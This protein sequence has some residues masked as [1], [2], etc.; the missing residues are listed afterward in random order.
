M[1]KQ[2][3]SQ[4][5]GRYQLLKI[6][7]KGGMGEVWL[8]YDPLYKR[9]VAIKCIRPELKKHE[10]LLYRFEHEARISA[11]LTHPGIV[12]IYEY[13]PDYY[14]M[15]YIAGKTLK[16]RIYQDR[17]S[18]GPLVA[19][20]FSVCH[21]I[22][23]IHAK[24]IL[25]RDLKPE[26]IL[27][28][29]FG[30]VILL[31]WGLAQELDVPMEDDDEDI[32]VEEGLT[33]PGKLVGTV[34]YMA[35][36]RALGQPASMQSEIYALGV[37]LYQILTLQLPFERPSLKEFAKQL[38]PR[39][40]EALD[41]EEVAPYRGIPPLLS[42]IVMRM[43]H[44]DPKHRYQDMESVLH[45]LTMHSEGRSDWLE[46]TKLSITRKSDWQFQENV[47]ISKHIALTG[48]VEESD[49][50]SV[51]ISKAAF[52]ENTRL[53]TRIWIDE[54]GAGIGFLLSIPEP[55]ERE[56]PFDG[57]CL[58]LA[59]SP[60][61][62]SLLFRNTVEVMNL[63]ELYLKKGEWHTIA[64]EKM[65]RSIR[66][67]VDGK[68][69]MTYISY[70]P[71]L[72]THVGII[73]K[74]ANFKLDE[75]LIKTG[76]QTL[77]VS[78]LAI[79]DAFLAHKHYKHALAEYRRIG[80]SFAGYAEGREG[81]FRA[82]ITLIEQ[83][84]NIKQRVKAD[85]LFQQALEDFSKLHGTAGAP[86][87]Y[88]GKSIVYQELGDHLEEIKCLELGLRRYAK[89]PLIDSLRDQVTYRMHEAAQ[90]DRR[91]AYQLMLL[92]LRLLPA[93][94]QRDDTQRLFA[95]LLKHWEPLAFLE[96]SLDAHFTEGKL[97]ALRFA[98]PL[99]F[100]LSAPYILMELYQDLLA[101]TVQDEAA[102]QDILFALCELGSY[103]LAHK[104]LAEQTAP[105]L[106]PI[107]LCHQTSLKEA[108]RT[109]QQLS[110]VDMGVKELRTL[111]YLMR[112]AL[113]QDQEEQVHHMADLATK[114]PL[115]KEDQIQIDAYRIWAFLKAED[116]R[117]AGKI[118]DL[119][120]LELLNQ[121][122]TLLHPLFGC[123]LYVTEGEEIAMIHFSGVIETPHPRSFALVGHEL[124]DHISQ[125]A[126][127]YQRSF[128]WE[129]RLLYSLLSLYYSLAE[130]PEQESYYKKLES[131][132]YIFAD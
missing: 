88:L 63:P 89:H 19:V 46:N 101:S 39:Y 28:G 69:K 103:Q 34:A 32:T 74:D 67:F 7:G 129:R 76:G 33:H 35:P 115:S 118:F 85:R 116:W 20:F 95:Y 65:G 23:Y 17:A 96:S 73:S 120:P 130:N 12:S 83:A 119:Y 126:N 92:V 99:A 43:I 94:L 104:L 70:L 123:Y 22:A 68:E 106:S 93:T 80:S 100:W 114:F 51:M 122:S 84:R 58:W 29:T 16:Q 54:E 48:N 26:N 121:E 56:S 107:F 45:D 131:E 49:W 109:Y 3:G 1:T 112:F 82:G 86:Y 6:I 38:R 50:V 9:E 110:L 90:T 72:G 47:L 15:P 55:A 10:K 81:L 62:L 132:E 52:A 40:T 71:L 36:E 57:Y 75:C 44:P 21:T 14:V 53:E 42:R 98:I 77:K 102:L 91:S 66:L 111:C 59:A 25:H 2:P 24:R 31:D 108:W 11:S 5:L 105:L 41:P 113:Y 125:A 4:T 27:V 79:P 97:S 8:A 30:E 64:L 78:C 87:E 18:I 60:H 128:M 127:W 124:S 37:I 13:T 117:S 61:S